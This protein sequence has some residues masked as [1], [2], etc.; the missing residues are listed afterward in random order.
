MK[1][2][3]SILKRWKTTSRE[4]ELNGRLPLITGIHLNLM[5]NNCR[6]IPLELITFFKSLKNGREPGS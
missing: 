1:T 4:E 6:Y 2:L 3:L 5:C